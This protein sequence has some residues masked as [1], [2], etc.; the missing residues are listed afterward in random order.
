MSLL[1]IGS[2][3]PE[4]KAKQVGLLFSHLPVILLA[5]SLNSVILTLTLWNH[6]SHSVL[7]SWLVCIQLTALLR[8]VLLLKYR[9]NPKRGS[10][11]RWFS[12][13]TWVSGICWGAGGV[14]LFTPGSVPHQ[15]F[16]TFVLGGMSAGAVTT[17]SANF[18]V[19]LAY[20]IPV[21][22]PLTVRLVGEGGQLHVAMGGMVGL[23]LILMVDISWRWY[24]TAL[25]LLTLEVT[26]GH[27]IT[28]LKSEIAERQ[29][30]EADL[31]KAR[32]FLEERVSE[33]TAELQ[34]AI[35]SVKVLRG[36]L[37]ICSSCKKIRDDQ[38][39]W[40]QL[41]TYIHQHSE[42]DFTHS[43]C[44]DCAERLFQGYVEQFS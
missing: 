4:V 29:Q 16:L 3:S 34:Q 37:P 2:D 21:L 27:L 36:L 25:T 18:R 35:D 15:T 30:I 11:G 12:V 43:L 42:A 5:T 24:R 10:W 14:L 40:T 19:V 13:G 39:Y 44:P 38:G 7:V 6:A 9:R 20:L 41:E 26:N 33:R 8:C 22:L 23:F 28:Q 1:P 17:L 31:K 32:D